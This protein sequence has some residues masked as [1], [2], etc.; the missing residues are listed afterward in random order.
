MR[1]S[2]QKFPMGNL[3]PAFFQRMLS[4]LSH[5]RKQTFMAYYCA[6]N[7][8]VFLGFLMQHVRYTKRNLLHNAECLRVG[9]AKTIMAS[10]EA[11]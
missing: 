4:S 5:R 8:H 2:S 3:P 11:H 6:L 1:R 10:L 7:T 9:N